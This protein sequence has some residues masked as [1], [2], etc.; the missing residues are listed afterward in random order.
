MQRHA[1]GRFYDAFPATAGLL[2][3]VFGFYLLEIVLGYKLS[4]DPTKGLWSHVLIGDP[5]VV[6]PLGGLSESLV[7]EDRQLWRL[8]AACFLHFGPI[9]ILFNCIVLMDLGRL[10][11]PMLGLHRF[12]TT[13]LACGVLASAASVGWQMLFGPALSAG[14]SGALCGLIGVLLGFSIRHRDRRLR[15]QMVRWVI[16]LAIF[17]IIIPFIDHAAHAGGL[18]AGFVFGLFVPSY[19]TSTAT[20]RWVVPAWLA[21]TACAVSLGFAIWGLFETL[22][23]I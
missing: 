8:L 10:L 20:T 5:R 1:T 17:S 6:I 13:Y 7:V 22:G 23:R 14:A 21:M 19:V 18:V 2:L 3:T 16:Y 12:I 11:E 4:D 9:H 15:E